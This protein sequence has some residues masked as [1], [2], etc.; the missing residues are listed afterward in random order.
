MPRPTD[1]TGVRQFLG[2]VNFLSKFIPKISDISEPLRQLTCKDTVFQWNEE[3]EKA[4]S[5]LKKAITEA[6]VLV[7]LKRGK[8]ITVQSD[9]SQYGLGAVLLQENKPIAFASRALT[10]TEEQ[11]AQ[12]E[13]ELLSVVYAMEKFD[14]YVYGR[15][16]T[17]HNDHQPLQTILKKPLHQ[18][19]K[20]L[21][22][23]ILQLQRYC[24]HLIYKPGKTMEVADA[25][26]RATCTATTA[27]KF[28]HELEKVCAVDVNIADPTLKRVAE[29]TKEDAV[30]QTVIKLT[31]AGWPEVSRRVP[32]EA[33]PYYS[34]RDELV[35][36]DGVLYKG[37]RCVIPKT[38]RR[39]ML[40][41][42]HTSHMGTEATLKRARETIYWPHINTEIRDYINKCDACQ[43]TARRQPKETLQQ[44]EIPQRVW[45][46]VGIDLFTFDN[47]DYMVI[48]D[49]LTNYWEIDCLH[50]GSTSMMVIKKAKAQFARH[51]VP[52]TVHSDNGP[53]FSSRDFKAFAQSWGFTHKTSSPMHPQS[54]GKAES[55]V[56]TAKTIMKRAR[57]AKTDAWKA[58]LEYRNTPSQGLGSSPAERFYE[59][60]TR[61]V[62]PSHPNLLGQPKTQ[63]RSDLQR[64]RDVQKKCYDRTAKDLPPLDIGDVVRI[65]PP[66]EK[67]EAPWREAVVEECLRNRSYRVRTYEGRLLR[68]NRRQLKKIWQQE[69]SGERAEERTHESQSQQE[70]T[71]AEEQTREEY[72][73]PYRTRFGRLVKQPTR[74]QSQD[75]R[76]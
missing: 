4:F 21:Q 17:V 25:L 49:Y 13:K 70:K 41:R 3:Q 53:Q 58:V 72:Q 7:Y 32:P 14:H 23:M 11:Y 24:F 30:L 67:G 26:S 40:A 38:M 74:Y 15:N 37:N 1:T 51:G 76:S 65:Q 16:V 35:T 19:P 36:E 50:E 22:R 9:A 60:C 47:R 6:S 27:S 61:G 8:E 28:Q 75:F 56:K 63:L 48:V 45:E 66:K 2:M 31:Q 55:A 71:T 39:E 73:G 62:V 29:C 12:I 57:D 42:L 44:Y 33:R 69:V 43:S 10:K 54:N 34:V 52:M 59:R 18:A 68:R 20:R 64:Q 5:R 46:T